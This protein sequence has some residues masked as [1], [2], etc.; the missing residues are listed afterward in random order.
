MLRDRL[1][2]GF[3]VELKTETIESTVSAFFDRTKTY[4][5]ISW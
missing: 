4:I 1:G 5:E 3:S 2:E